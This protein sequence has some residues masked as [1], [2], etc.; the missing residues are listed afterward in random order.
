MN[1]T[2]GS[3]LCSVLI[4]NTLA[5]GGGGWAGGAR[6]LRVFRLEDG[7]LRKSDDDDK[8]RSA[9][10]RRRT[11]RTCAWTASGSRRNGHPCRRR[12]HEMR[13]RWW[14]DRIP[15]DKR[16]DTHCARPGGA[17]ALYLTQHRS[18]LSLAYADR[19]CGRY[20][21]SSRYARWRGAERT[22]PAEQ[23]PPLR[24]SRTSITCERESCSSVTGSAFNLCAGRWQAA[25]GHREGRAQRVKQADR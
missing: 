6:H 16:E 24:M 2:K 8:E 21:R 7:C 5:A 25:V 18:T 19:R 14:S 12:I 13:G 22:V 1:S 20:G 3:C 4:E 10:N 11:R 9:S 15:G 17:R 23:R